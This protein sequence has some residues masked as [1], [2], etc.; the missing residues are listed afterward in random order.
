MSERENLDVHTSKNKTKLKR[1]V[2]FSEETRCGDLLTGKFYGFLKVSFGVDTL[3][4]VCGG[5][6]CLP[7][8]V[9][10]C[11]EKDQKI[12]RQEKNKTKKIGKKFCL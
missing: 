8:L 11:P 2:F 1:T 4:N 9:Q 3:F 10:I 6:R 12:I 5:Q 7:G